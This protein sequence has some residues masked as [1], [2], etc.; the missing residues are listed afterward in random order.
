MTGYRAP[1]ADMQFTLETVCDWPALNALPAV[2]E[3][4]PDLVTAVLEEAGKLAGNVVAPLNRSGDQQGSRLSGDAVT[5]P[6]G[7]ADAYRQYVK[8]GWNGLEADPDYGGQGLPFSLAL[9]V[10]EMFAA[11]NLSFSLCPML[12]QG[13]IQAMQAHAT[14]ELKSVYLDKM[15]SGEWTGSMNLTE[16][17]AG[18]DVGALKTK[19]A[20]NGDGSWSITGQKIYITWGEHDM[21]D[22]IVHLVLARTPDAPPGTRGI[23]M[24]LVPKFLP[25]ESG[26]P[27]ERNDVRCTGLEEKL[28]IHASPTCV[29]QFG[30]QGGA[31]GW[32]VGEENK[33]MR[34]MFTMMNHARINV[35]LQGVAIAEAAYQQAAAFAR[36]RVQSADIAAPGGSAVPII[37]HADV[38]RMLMSLRAIAQGLR[39]LAYFNAAAVD[40]AHAPEDDDARRQAQGLADL[41]TPVT[42]AFATD[43][44]VEAASIAI[45][46]HGGMGYVEETG[47]A[48]LLRDARIAPIYEGTNGIQAMDLVGR[49]L[50]QDGGAHWRALFQ[51]MRDFTGDL[52]GQGDLGALAP[53]LEDGVAALQNAA[54]W[55]S[56]NDADE[57]RDT[58]AGATPFLRMMGTALCGYL[59]AREAV[60]AA[61]RLEDGAG[62]PAFLKA[63]IATARFWCEQYLP[64]ATALL[65]PVTR[66]ADMLYALDEA[67]FGG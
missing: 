18:S 66:G 11:A 38:R 25:D 15:I 10:Q 58:A 53:Y 30:E 34:N 4:T 6:E 20:P 5:T 31:K 14:D 60:A 42:K 49:K 16:P 62:D 28:G 26:A 23:S 35:G 12:N 39:A 40:R 13:A 56:G 54:V 9:A 1:L 3:A 63:R 51:E 64:S 21:A 43:I 48:Q 32:L 22:N 57:I 59:L 46:V 61:A 24:F 33:G 55:L 36:D 29:M 2:A 41:L 8:G 67:Q 44:G 37:R 65:G 47:V 27:G 19:A 17:Q 50:G 52:P 7:F 45:Q